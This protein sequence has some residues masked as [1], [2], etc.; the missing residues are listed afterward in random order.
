M[1]GG[2]GK[3]YWESVGSNGQTAYTPMDLDDAQYRWFGP[4]QPNEGVMTSEELFV[5]IMTKGR[6]VSY[7]WY[8]ENAFLFPLFYTM[9]Y[10]CEADYVSDV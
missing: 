8:S 9:S 2:D 6:D 1:Y 10:I 5:A 3:W 7:R 4:G